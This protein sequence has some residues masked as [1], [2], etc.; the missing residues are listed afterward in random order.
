MMPIATISLITAD[1]SCCWLTAGHVGA[2]PKRVLDAGDPDTRWGS[3]TSGWTGIAG[4]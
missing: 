2:R 1:Q 3:L 4:A